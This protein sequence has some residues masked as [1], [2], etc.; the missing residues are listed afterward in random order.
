MFIFLITGSISCFLLFL[1]NENVLF[2]LT[3]SILREV[4]YRR[5]GVQK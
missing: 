3:L 1:F 4:Y 5:I 2:P